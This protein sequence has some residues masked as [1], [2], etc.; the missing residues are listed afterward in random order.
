ML[1]KKCS[2]CKE[3]KFVSEFSNNKAAHDGLNYYCKP[4]LSSIKRMTHYKSNKN[5][6]ELE[7]KL[8]HLYGDWLTYNEIRQYKEHARY[9]S[10]TRE[11]K[12][13]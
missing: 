3:E 6:T 4:C 7:I 9:Y 1:T 13:I 10:K 5:H 12:V 8:K 2:K 11:I